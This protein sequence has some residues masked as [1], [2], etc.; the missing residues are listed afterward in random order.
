[1]AVKFKKEV[2]PKPADVI[3]IRLPEE[4]KDRIEILC[5]RED[6]NLSS[7]CRILITEALEKRG[8]HAT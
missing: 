8:N 5:A 1:M 6:R 7:M 3:Y 4:T 2:K